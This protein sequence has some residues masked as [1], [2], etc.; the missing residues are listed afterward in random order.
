M[1]GICQILFFFPIPYSLIKVNFIPG[2]IC[3][4]GKLPFSFLYSVP[5]YKA[6]VFVLYKLCCLDPIVYVAIGSMH[7]TLP[8]II[9]TFY[10]VA[11]T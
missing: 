4:G 5:E 10:F 8:F 6:T 3:L 9:T 11:F 2:K 7:Y 1:L